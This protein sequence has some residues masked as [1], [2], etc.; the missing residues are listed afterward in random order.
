[1]KPF[2][3]LRACLPAAALVLASIPGTASTAAQDG[4]P[5]QP[6]LNQPGKDVQ[7]VPTPPALIEKML[8]MAKVTPKDYL[9]DL[10]SGDGRTVITAAKRGLRAH[11]IEYNPDMVELSKSNAAKAGV[12]DKATSPGSMNGSTVVSASPTPRRIRP[13]ARRRRV[14]G[15][16]R[17]AGSARMCAASRCASASRSGSTGRKPARQ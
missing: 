7:W 2:V 17:C 4:Q 3:I 5:Y 11:G 6:E 8:D 14:R 13:V 16:D 9:I 12:S 1:M 10:G 15:D